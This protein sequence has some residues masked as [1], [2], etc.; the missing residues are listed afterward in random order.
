M[1]SVPI[2]LLK[3]TVSTVKKTIYYAELLQDLLEQKK[4]ALATQMIKKKPKALLAFFVPNVPW[5]WRTHSRFIA[6]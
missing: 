5:D 1:H 2:Q 4:K 6:R 3:K